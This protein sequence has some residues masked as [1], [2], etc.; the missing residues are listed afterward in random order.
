[1]LADLDL[2]TLVG[3]SVDNS[4]GAKLVR[5]QRCGRSSLLWSGLVLIEPWGC[6][7]FL[8]DFFAFPFLA[9]FGSLKLGFLSLAHLA[10]CLCCTYTCRSVGSMV[11]SFI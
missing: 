10:F 7:L 3:A 1:M 2:S 5:N 9:I 11:Q 6:V 8:N 4:V